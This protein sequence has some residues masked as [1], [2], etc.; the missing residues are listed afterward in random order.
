VVVVVAVDVV[1]V[2]AGAIEVSVAAVVV[3]VPVEVIAEV[4]VD[5]DVS[6][7]V[8]VWP[9]AATPNARTAAAAAAR[10]SLNLVIGAIPLVSAKRSGLNALEATPCPG[11]TLLASGPPLG[12]HA[13][14]HNGESGHQ[15]S[16]AAAK[17][18][19]S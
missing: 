8:D 1:V 17:A 14:S 9:Q 10:P 6:V 16:V 2:V 11:L 18:S 19:S 7:E 4:S 13:K 5:A 12:G 3:D 15:A